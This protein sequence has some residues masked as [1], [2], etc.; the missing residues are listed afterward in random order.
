MTLL[1][2]NCFY[3]FAS[4][5]SKRQHSLE[6]PTSNVRISWTR[7][8]IYFCKQDLGTIRGKWNIK[9]KENKQTHAEIPRGCGRNGKAPGWVGVWAG[10]CPGLTVKPPAAFAT[11][12]PLSIERSLA[13]W[14]PL[15]QGCRPAIFFRNSP[16]IDTSGPCSLLVE[17]LQL[18]LPGTHSE[19]HI[20]PPSPLSGL[21][22]MS[23]P[24]VFTE[25]LSKNLH[26]LT[27]LV[28]FYQPSLL[29][30]SSNHLTL[31]TLLYI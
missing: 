25:S 3:F 12:E 18:S 27:W 8:L 21:C 24:L 30:L 28:T 11:S 29:Y 1:P 2:A 17:H 9:N 20:V 7:C 10:P 4:L 23:P 16:R 14:C 26:S 6:G 22:W 31:A 5:W 13:G 15:L 19:T